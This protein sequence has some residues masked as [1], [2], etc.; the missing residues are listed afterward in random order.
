MTNHC[1]KEKKDSGVIL[2]HGL[3]RTKRSM[4]SLAKALKRAGYS[5]VNGG[6]PSRRDP[7]EALAAE[8]IS[9]AIDELRQQGLTKIHVVT[10][11]MGGILL[12]SYLA[13]NEI[14]ELGRVVM[15]S[16]PNRGSEL[17]DALAHYWWFRLFNGPAGCQLGTNPDS[18]P[19]RLGPVDFET[20]VITGNRPLNPFFARLIPGESDGKVSVERAR[21]DGMTDFLVLPYSHSFIMVRKVVIDQVLHFLQYGVFQR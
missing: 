3:A 19:N 17:V 4:G 6:Y 5:V 7:V 14:E 8:V 12:R 10:H 16:P 13:S 11:S 21:V 1:N 2:L 15:L 9:Q 18:V 20:G